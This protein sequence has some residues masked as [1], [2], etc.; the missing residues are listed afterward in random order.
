MP[1]RP[2]C[3]TTCAVGPQARK[4]TA[5]RASAHE[6]WSWVLCRSKPQPAGRYVVPA[7]GVDQISRDQI[8]SSRHT[9]PRDRRAPTFFTSKQPGELPAVLSANLPW[10]AGYRRE[11]VKDSATEARTQELVEN[12]PEFCGS[13]GSLRCARRLKL[14]AHRLQDQMEIRAGRL[15]R[16]R[17]H[18]NGGAP[19]SIGGT[20]RG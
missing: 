11:R 18:P 12:S 5:R 13:F 20:I 8:L 16:K 15:Q 7:A 6:S 14:N 10:L 9:P 19:P 4:K 2:Y 3:A 17:H 1:G